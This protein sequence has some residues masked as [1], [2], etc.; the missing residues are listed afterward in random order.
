MPDNPMSPLRQCKIDDMTA[1]R[2]KEKVRW[3]LL[4]QGLV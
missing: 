1:R 4:A 3:P 2:V